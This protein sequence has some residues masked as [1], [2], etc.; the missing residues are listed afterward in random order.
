LVFVS[1]D[2]ESLAKGWITQYRGYQGT[3]KVSDCIEGG[4]WIAQGTTY[5][6]REGQGWILFLIIIDKWNQMHIGS[7]P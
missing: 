3:W 6:I 5:Q 7:V 2:R 1:F 4:G